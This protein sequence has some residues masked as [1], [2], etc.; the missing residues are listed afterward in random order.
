MSGKKGE[1]SNSKIYFAQTDTTAGLLSRNPV[2][3]N[4]LKGRNENQPILREV[5][6]LETLQTFVRVPRPFRREVRFRRQTTYIYLPKGEGIRVVDEGLHHSF[7][8]KFRWLYSTSANRT[9]EKFNLEWGKRVADEVVE[10][11]RG[12][13]DAPPSQLYR[14][15][16]TRKIRIR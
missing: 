9:G 13:F 15:G 10:D 5:D 8:K 7:L 4:R 16:R 11:S 12:F 6:S 3:L 2:K 14:L 1:I